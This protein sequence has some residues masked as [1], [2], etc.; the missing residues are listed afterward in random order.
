[1]ARTFLG[2]L[3]LIALIACGGGS[4]ERRPTTGSRTPAASRSKPSATAP[5]TSKRVK[6]AP[7][8]TTAKPDTASRN[9]L[10]NR[11]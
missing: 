5:R 3:A 8:K 4:E 9:P 10:T 2:G 11:P 6:K 7:R 1:M